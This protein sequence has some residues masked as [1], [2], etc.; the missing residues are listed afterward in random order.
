MK[1]RFPAIILALALCLGLA[2]LPAP[3]FAAGTQKSVTVGSMTFSEVLTTNC[4]GSLG[5][6]YKEEG[7]ATEPWN[8]FNYALGTQMVWWNE[9]PSTP[10]NEFVGIRTFWCFF[11]PSDA[12]ITFH[13][14]EEDV[15]YYQG[16]T[17]EYYQRRSDGQ[18]F[19]KT[20]VVEDKSRYFTVPAPGNYVQTK[21]D[22]QENIPEEFDMLTLQVSDEDFVQIWFVDQIPVPPFTDV[23]G[24]CTEPVTWAAANEITQGTGD[25]KFSPGDDCTHVQILTFLWRAENRLDSAATAFDHLAGDYAPAANWAYEKGLI[26]DSF[27][28]QAPCTRAQAVSYIWQT[29]GEEDAQASS[30]PDVDAGADYAKAVDWAVEN[31]I[32]E[33]YPDGTFGPDTV[34]SRGVIAALLHRTYVEEARLNAKS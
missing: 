7:E 13:L 33:G 26:D 21:A 5:A 34:C 1:K 14:T 24:W 11:L 2:S 32:V 25:G 16:W 18:H 28:P 10:E 9:D 3:A 6:W 27:D 30:F 20:E 19:W 8:D 22:F 23:D 17:A 31:G 29:L 12:S 4:Y 15:V